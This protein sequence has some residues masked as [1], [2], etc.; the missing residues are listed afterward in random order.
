M[1]PCLARCF[2]C[3]STAHGRTPAGLRAVPA[4]LTLRLVFLAF[5]LCTWP[6]PAQTFTV[7]YAF[8]GGADG[9]EPYATLVLDNTGNLYGT[10]YAGGAF[11]KG[12]VFKVDNSGKETVLHSFAATPDGAYPLAGLLIGSEGSFYGTTEGG[13]SGGYGVVWKIAP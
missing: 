9:R 2:C 7:L 12:T 11:D 3:N 8:T 1:K 10:T 13:G 6:A 5:V 4:R